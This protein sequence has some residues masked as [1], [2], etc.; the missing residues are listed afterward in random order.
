MTVFPLLH[1]SVAACMLAFCACA[2]AQVPAPP[3]AP[4]T[5]AALMMPMTPATPVTDEYFGTQVVDPYRWMENMKSDIFRD[6]AH[7]QA[8]YASGMLDRIP[9]REALKKR[10]AE[11]NN[12][13]E[14]ISAIENIG[15]RLYFLKSE[16]G[17]NARRLFMRDANGSERLLLD[18]DAM[19]AQGSHNAIDFFTPSPDG[20]LLAIGISKGGSEDSILRLMDI[21]SG[22]WLPDAIDGAGLNHNGI[23]W[24]PNGRAFFYN[25]LPNADR[26]GH[27]ERYNKSAVYE[28]VVG[29]AVTMD[30]AIFGYGV[31]IKRH[32]AV[33]DLPYVVTSPDSNYA[34]AIVLHG[35]AV[36]RS[37]YVAP[38]SSVNGPETPWRKI[39]GPQ[40]QVNTAYLHGN[41]L[42]VLSHKN[43]P[44]YQLLALSLAEAA[45]AATPSKPA[46]RARH[47]KVAKSKVQAK[48]A[49]VAN[50]PMPDAVRSRVV[51]ARG[52]MVLRHAAVAKDALYVRALDGGVSRLL[53]VPYD[54]A[55]SGKPV[56]TI[57]LPFDGT[58]LEMAT[59]PMQ[60]GVLVKL[61][62]WTESPR[63]YTVDA[64][65]AQVADSGLLKPSPI[66][67]AD[68]ETK[69]VLVKSHDGTAVPL[70]ILSRKGIPLDGS[71]PAIINGYGAYGI[72]LEPRFVPGR[73]AWLERGGVFAVA[74]VRGGGE[75]GEE[76]HMGAHIIN[77]ANTIRDFIACAEYLVKE[78]YTSPKKLAGT[79]GS[80]GGLTIGGAITQRPELFAA[81]QSAVGLADMLRMELTPNGPPN[82]A[83]FGT[84]TKK[85]QF[86]AMYAISPY[87]RVQDGVA[88]PATIVTTGINDPRVDAWEPAKFAARLQTATASGKPVLLRIDYDGGHGIGSTKA[89]SIAETADV[90]AF[91]LW[92]MGDPAFQPA[93]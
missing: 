28:H 44:R 29:Q 59:D 53:R 79:G 60:P 70:S 18:P 69:R 81:A 86:A 38:L 37:F 21:A 78:G 48:A 43:A 5:S 3:P 4:A 11:L 14:N 40:D 67:F 25:R 49:R 80:A 39:V 92:Q 52:D 17:R 19:D 1:K 22:N 9:G 6:W 20:K 93:K 16:P 72:T 36:D 65:S 47:G 41:E 2:V 57:T 10:L 46:P 32:F 8:D 74:H 71:N 64:A 54:T 55:V 84:V 85:D 23:G 82:I 12:A 31:T 87:H 51:I 33:P 75:F 15:G 66:S 63:I 56:Q 73:L 76:W 89:Q 42:F 45:R 91:F 62:G 30:K 34:I 26:D 77:K 50:A 68:V 24:R 35:D 13:S 58:V 83:E 27:R 88:Y 7:A 61:E 90:W